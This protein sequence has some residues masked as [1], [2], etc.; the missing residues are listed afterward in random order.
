MR[1]LPR[2]PGR[3][4]AICLAIYRV[5]SLNAAQA[6]VSVWRGTI[7]RTIFT[8]RISATNEFR[9]KAPDGLEQVRC[10]FAQR[11]TEPEGARQSLRDSDPA[12]VQGRGGDPPRSS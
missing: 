10:R 11:G 9:S 7:E 8:T 5:R 3:G 2:A 4:R 1:S 6:H 12:G